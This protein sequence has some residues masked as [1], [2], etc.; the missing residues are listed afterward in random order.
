[1]AFGSCFLPICVDS[2]RTGFPGKKF[3]CLFYRMVQCKEKQLLGEED[4]FHGGNYLAFKAFK[5][6]KILVMGGSCPWIKANFAFLH[7]QTWIKN[8]NENSL[9]W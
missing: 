6:V 1:M 3:S 4:K 2:K 9:S 7:Y 5:F 8:I